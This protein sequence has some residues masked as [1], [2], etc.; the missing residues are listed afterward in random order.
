MRSNR[1]PALVLSGGTSGEGREL[2]LVIRRAIARFRLTNP[3]IVELSPRD[4]DALQLRAGSAQL[5]DELTDPA[6][7]VAL[8]GGLPVEFVNRDDYYHPSP[9]P[10][11]RGL[12]TA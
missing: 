4:R 10:A 5:L 11:R 3:D 1:R 9:A 6:R 7:G 12:T 8:P 2:A